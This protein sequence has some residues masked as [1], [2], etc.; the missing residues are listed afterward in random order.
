MLT[1]KVSDGFN[2]YNLPIKLDL[3]KLILVKPTLPSTGEDTVDPN[4]F[5]LLLMTTGVLFVRTGRQLRKES[6]K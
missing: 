6:S 4:L 1:A 3:Q 5:A 2:E